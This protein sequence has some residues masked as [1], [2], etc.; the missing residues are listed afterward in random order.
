MEEVVDPVEVDAARRHEPPDDLG[1]GEA[2]G[3]GKARP[4]V[5]FRE[6]PPVAADGSLDAKEGRRFFRA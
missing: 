4:L 6:L 2:L 1:Q 3:H 5:R